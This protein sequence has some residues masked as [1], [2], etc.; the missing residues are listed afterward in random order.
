MVIGAADLDDFVDL[1]D[2]R[3]TLRILWFGEQIASE[4]VSPEGK[5]KP[6]QLYLKGL[7]DAGAS[8]VEGDFGGSPRN[9]NHQIACV[10][11]CLKFLADIDNSVIYK[12]SKFQF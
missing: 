9:Q 6:N 4:E 10:Q 8:C 2:V 11:F 7:R 3:Q 1:L 5:I 12:R